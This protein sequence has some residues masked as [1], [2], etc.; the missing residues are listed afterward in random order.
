ME[1]I[2]LI[3][4]YNTFTQGIM[5]TVKD[6]YEIQMSSDDPTLAIQ[7]LGSDSFNLIIISLIGFN[8]NHNDIFFEIFNN[9]E[10]IPVICV[11][12]VNDKHLFDLYFKD[13]QFE[14]LPYPITNQEIL[15]NINRRLNKADEPIVEE[16]VVSPINSRY[17][18][19]PAYT[20]VQ[21]HILLVDDNA[22]QLRSLKASLSQ[23]YQ[24][25]MATSAAQAMTVIGRQ[26]PDLIFLDYEMPIVDGRQ[27]LAMIRELESTRDIPVV[28]LTSHNDR[29]HIS[30]VMG[31]NPTGYLLKPPD[32]P[33][34]MEL[35]KKL[36]NE[37][38]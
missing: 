3:G 21:K 5:K 34:I 23:K 31:L 14:F 38:R 19:R 30:S 29:E 26:K 8:E 24:V 33:K 7:M 18:P 16:P 20:A 36:L 37:V 25:S 17:A 10:T 22:V 1:K 11:G 28:F 32:I 15:R 2:L 12:N 27:T 6:S 13:W 4:R 35:A 9:Y